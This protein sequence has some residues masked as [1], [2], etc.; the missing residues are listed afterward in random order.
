M[1]L[2]GFFRKSVGTAVAA[3]MENCA[4]SAATR[5]VSANCSVVCGGAASA[6]WL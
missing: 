6:S 5:V 1:S 2:V 3:V 4:G